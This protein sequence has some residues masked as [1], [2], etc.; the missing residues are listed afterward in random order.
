MVIGTITKCTTYSQWSTFGPQLLL[1]RPRLGIISVAAVV[2]GVLRVS[3]NG[4]SAPIFGRI[5][6]PAAFHDSRLARLLTL[7][8]YAARH[9]WLLVWP[10]HLAFDRSYD[11]IP[12]IHSWSDSRNGLTLAAYA[13]LFLLASAGAG[14][15]WQRHLSLRERRCLALGLLLLV[16]P[17][18][19]SSNLFF[20]V[21]FT[22]AERVLYTPSMGF[23]L[24][25]ATL[26]ARLERVHRHWRRPARSALYIGLGLYLARSMLRNGVWHDHESLGRS[27]L[28]SD[29][30]N[31]KI[32][33]ITAHGIIENNG[34]V[35]EAEKHLHVGLRLS[36]RLGY[37]RDKVLF[38][39]FEQA[40]TLAFNNRDFFVAERIFRYYLSE[41]SAN[42]HV[43][44][45]Y[46]RTLYELGQLD[47]SGRE[48][49]EAARRNAS[50][51]TPRVWA[52][53]VI[54]NFMATGQDEAAHQLAEQF[55]SLYPRDAPLRALW[56][57]SLR[58]D[59]RLQEA[60]DQGLAATRL[61]ASDPGVH[62]TLGHSYAQLKR[63]RAAAVHYG[64]VAE[65]GGADATLLANLAAVLHLAGDT[66]KAI[67]FAK[68]ARLALPG[69]VFR[70]RA[71][72]EMLTALGR[73]DDAAA[74][75]QA[76]AAAGLKM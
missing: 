59:G 43:R 63:Y 23:C 72:A 76:A 12:L 58:R 44:A 25:I 65:L 42:N 57:N 74:V 36:D 73:H 37:T 24:L 32:R 45:S 38:Q 21:G 66:A 34:S 3:W 56:A 51:T 30:I 15:A 11:T 8:Y 67:P 5:E 40:A 54:N 53:D 14:S 4:E 49:L 20:P 2:V 29:L 55:V 64:M 48:L 6:N 13:V 1:P 71:E 70:Y 7:H 27:G 18:V 17:H 60:V 46:G 62:Q 39:N 26:F 75:Q 9:L 61:N 47:A 22:V 68:Q 50:M 41:N 69:D 33:M 31:P 19:P 52:C 35:A 16:L 28:R 10:V